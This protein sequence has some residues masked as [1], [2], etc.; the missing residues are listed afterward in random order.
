MQTKQL[1]LIVSSLIILMICIGVMVFISGTSWFLTD[2]SSDQ[3]E[4]TRS[5]ILLPLS[6]KPTATLAVLAD[7]NP[8]ATDSP[9]PT[10]MPTSTPLPTEVIIIEEATVPVLTSV[11]EPTVV[12]TESGSSM[13]QAEVVDT[14]TIAL[15]AGSVSVNN[16][17]GL[18]SKLVI[19]KL[20][21]DAPVVLAPIRNGTW[22]VEHLGQDLVGHLEGTAPVGSESNIV[23]AAH[24]T[25]DIGVYGPFAGLALLENGDEVMV[26]DEQNQIHRYQITERQ[27]VD[28]SN[29]KVAY[30]TDESQITLITCSRWSQEDGRYLDRLVIKG[31][32]VTE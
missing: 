32:L 13:A 16:S 5:R 6:N 31:T 23:L 20:D 11:P 3:P 2:I 12:E 21:L 18:A 8:T 7:V 27:I 25:I 1:F 29:V 30:P 15:P 14:Q 17:V 22:E 9:S 24:V 4:D 10:V 19:P 28:R 26:Y